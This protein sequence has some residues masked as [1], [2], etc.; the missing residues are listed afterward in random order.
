MSPAEFIAEV[1]Q[2]LAGRKALIGEHADH[3]WRP[4][5]DGGGLCIKLP[6]EKDG[7]QSGHHLDVTARNN[8]PFYAFSISV[9]AHGEIAVA[10][11]DFEAPWDTHG[12]NAADWQ[13]DVERFP[14]GRLKIIYGPHYHGWGMNRRFVATTREQLKLPNAASLPSNVRDFD[15]AIRW[16]CNQNN[17]TLS[18]N[19]TIRLPPQRLI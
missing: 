13:D 15:A 18:H 1:D 12:N 11:L 7:V 17:I 9:I 16:F 14:D 6:L 2:F 3:Q 19:H 8:Q 5:R 4:A 10:R